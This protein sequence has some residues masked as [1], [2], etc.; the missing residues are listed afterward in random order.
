MVPVGLPPEQR[1]FRIQAFPP[2]PRPTPV[3]AY[4]GWELPSR[5]SPKEQRKGRFKRTGPCLFGP[6]LPGAE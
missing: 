1:P 2:T 4:R 6:A 3:Q 5:R